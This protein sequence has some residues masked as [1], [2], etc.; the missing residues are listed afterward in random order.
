MCAQSAP[1]LL[2]EL[3]PYLAPVLEER[4]LPGCGMQVGFFCLNA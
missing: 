1:E 3:L 2:E 4:L